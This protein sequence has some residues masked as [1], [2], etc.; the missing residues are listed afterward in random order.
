VTVASANVDAGANQ[1]VCENT[2]F[3]LTATPVGSADNPTF[4]WEPTGSVGSVVT[5]P[6][7]ATA[8]FK[9][10]MFYSAANCLASDTVKVTV[11]AAPDIDSLIIIP[12]SSAVCEGTPIQLRAVTTPANVTYEWKRKIG[13]SEETLTS[14]ASTVNNDQ[15]GASNGQT[16]RYSVIA[17]NASGCRSAESSVDFNV[18]RCWAV[19]NIFTPGNGDDVNNT[20]GLVLQGGELELESFRVYSRWGEKVFEATGAIKSWDGKI[21][22]KD[23]PSDVY[24]YYMKFLYPD[25][26]TEEVKGDVTLLR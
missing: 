10:N 21:N 12:D 23:A 13:D 18:I 2:Q 1:S 17:S 25:G 16:V 14:T 22:D 15:S 24:V 5:L 26:S 11:I 6:A 8:T 3:T 19:P 4:T 7:L 9:V 20:F